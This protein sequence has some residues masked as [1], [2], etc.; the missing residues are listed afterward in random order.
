M[1]EFVG[2]EGIKEAEINK[3]DVT[4]GLPS[5]NSLKIPGNIKLEV[6][7]DEDWNLEESNISNVTPICN[8]SAV[9]NDEEEE[10]EEEK[11]LNKSPP[12][13]LS[14]NN[15]PEMELHSFQVVDNLAD[16]TPMSQKSQSSSSKDTITKSKI[17]LHSFQFGKN[18]AEFASISQ[19]S[20]SS[21]SN[22]IITKSQ[23]ENLDQPVTAVPNKLVS[24]IPMREAMNKKKRPLSKSCKAFFV[25]LLVTIY[26]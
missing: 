20:Q 19:K 18:V 12:P 16:F 14:M 7:D 10:E 15:A 8:K 9:W 2:E 6:N 17:E 22:D 3:E 26:V 11:E 25:G 1:K 5:A 21:S 13:F 4:L 24:R 23:I